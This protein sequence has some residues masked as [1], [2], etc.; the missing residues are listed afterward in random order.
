MLGLTRTRPPSPSV[1][2]LQAGAT[3]AVDAARRHD[4][5]HV[6]VGVHFVLLGGVGRRL[7][8]E[9][10]D[11][12]PVLYSSHF[13]PQ[14]QAGRLGLL[15]ERFAHDAMCFGGQRHDRCRGS[16]FFG[17]GGHGIESTASGLDGRRPASSYP[18]QTLYR[19]AR[20]ET[21]RRHP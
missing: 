16:Q 18:W 12:R 15:V 17:S 9:V 19:R 3:Q 11:E 1:G 14:R 2:P 20:G 4:D 13:E 21:P 10:V 7:E 6:A 5:L 8:E